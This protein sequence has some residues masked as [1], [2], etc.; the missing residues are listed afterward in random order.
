MAKTVTFNSTIILYSPLPRTNSGFR[1][2]TVRDAELRFS[3]NIF[4]ES[5]ITLEQ[6]AKG[7]HHPL[8]IRDT[9]NALADEIK[10]KRGNLGI[11]ASVPLSSDDPFT[12]TLDARE[13]FRANKKLEDLPKSVRDLNW[14]HCLERDSKIILATQHPRTY[15]ITKLTVDTRN[16]RHVLSVPLPIDEVRQAL[17]AQTFQ[18]RSMVIDLRSK[19]ADQVKEDSQRISAALREQTNQSLDALRQARLVRTDM[20]LSC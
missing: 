5:D 11:N 10:Q 20:R 2:K 14:I 15:D 9:F 3:A 12:I 17:D 4:E 19:F 13:I 16:E 18:G 6:K 1:E 7:Q 8:Y